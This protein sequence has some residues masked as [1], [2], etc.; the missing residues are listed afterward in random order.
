MET[1]NSFS[2]SGALAS[3]GVGD[4]EGVLLSEP[5]GVDAGRGISWIGEGWGLFREAPGMW[6]GIVLVLGVIFIVLSMLPLIN[7]LVSLVM[8]VFVGGL[9]LGCRDLARGDGLEFGHLFAG[10]KSHFGKLVTAGLLY[11][12]GTFVV[13]VGVMLT[14]VGSMGLSALA[15]GDMA[16]VDPMSVLPAM[17]VAMLLILPL[18]MTV[19]FA[20]A[21]IVLHDAAVVEAMS[22][23][24]KGCLR[25][26]LPFLIYGIVMAVL[27]FVASIPL[28]LGWL[29]LGPVM[30]ASQYNAYRDI[31]LE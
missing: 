4:G 12:V 31:F 1:N 30:I 7:L 17:L 11:A 29:L 6:V 16:G 20:P 5:R 3:D 8:P 24:F 14:M 22:L 23:S 13:M 9:M 18:A 26:I 27:A 10:F 28:M 19:Y 15:G 25:N 21:L 2:A